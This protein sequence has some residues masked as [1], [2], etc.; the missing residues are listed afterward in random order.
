MSKT[1]KLYYEDGTESAWISNPDLQKQ[2]LTTDPR[3]I[4]AL[5]VKELMIKKEA[6]EYLKKL[7]S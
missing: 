1:I 6:E 5:Y 2:V 4:K 3:N 7:R